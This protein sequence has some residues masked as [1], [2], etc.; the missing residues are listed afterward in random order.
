MSQQSSSG[1]ILRRW[2]RRWF[3]NGHNVNSH[4][5]GVNVQVGNILATDLHFHSRVTL[6]RQVANVPFQVAEL[7]MLLQIE[8]RACNQIFVSLA[9]EGRDPRLPQKTLCHLE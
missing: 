5:H 4:G 9:S 6:I 2:M 8:F 3:N 7:R 1:M